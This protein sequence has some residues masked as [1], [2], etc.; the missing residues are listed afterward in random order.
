MPIASFTRTRT[1]ALVS[2]LGNDVMGARRGF[3]DTPPGVVSNA[4]TLAL[5]LAGSGVRDAGSARHRT[6]ARLLTR[7]GRYAEL[8]V[9]QFRDETAARPARARQHCGSWVGEIHSPQFCFAVVAGHYAGCVRRIVLA[10]GCVVTLLG[11][12]TS[13]RNPG[14]PPGPSQ[15]TTPEQAC[16]ADRW[17]RPVPNVTGQLMPQA[18]DGSLFCF[19]VAKATAADGHDVLHDVFSKA[20]NYRITSVSPAA[21]L[22]VG[23]GDPIAVRVAPVDPSQPPASRPCDWVTTDEAARF[24]GTQSVTTMPVGDQA[25]SVDQMCDYTSTSPDQM[26]VSELQLP[27]SLPV[28]ANT[29]FAMTV[30]AGGGSDVGGLPGR[31]YCSSSPSTSMLVVLLGG[32]RLYRVTDDNCDVLKQFAQT[33]IPRIGA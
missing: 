33:A 14:A 24:L 21:G 13:T 2:R 5:T 30:A 22:A 20:P 32:D 19:K 6:H 26:V 7:G 1:G 31:A 27:G 10:A 4:V 23:P 3:S 18:L 11:G 12:C 8:Y 25:G 28:D 15:P 29:E 9:A 16:V 17:P